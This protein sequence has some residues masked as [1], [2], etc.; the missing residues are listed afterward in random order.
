MVWNIHDTF[1]KTWMGELLADFGMVETERQVVSEVRKIDLV[2]YPRSNNPIDLSVL[3]LLGR[4]LSRPCPIEFFR[5]AV[6][7]DEITNCR[8]KG[9]D[10][11]AELRRQAAQNGVTIDKKNPPLLWII[12][13]TMSQKMQDRFRV[14]TKP[15]WGKGIYFLPEDDLTAVVVV[16]RLPVN[17]D[18]IWLR[19][20]G[21]G[22]VQARAVR[23]VL[24]LP[25]DYPYRAETL[26]HPAIPN[27]KD[28][29]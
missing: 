8:D 27:S 12:S 17:I 15:E 20:L 26:R 18:T 16:H 25:E 14:I 21:K 9:A 5:N 13:P 22:T 28:Y 6:P 24:A 4:M 3:G 7:A 10:L 29:A 11:R 2:F 19:L 23:E 1:A